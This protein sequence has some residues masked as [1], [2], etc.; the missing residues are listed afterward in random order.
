MVDTR[1]RV[2][3]DLPEG[4]HHQNIV[5]EIGGSKAGTNIYTVA[6]C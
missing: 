1:Q 6:M 3:T 5:G 4:E 2:N